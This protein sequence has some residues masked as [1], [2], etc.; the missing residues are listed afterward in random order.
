MPRGAQH[1]LEIGGAERALARLVDHRLAGERRELGNDLPARL[2]AH[3]DAAA[4]ARIA[5]AGADLLRAPALVG[6]QVGEVGAM[7]FA[8][9]D[10]VPARLARGGQQLLDRLDRR[11]G[12]RQVVAHLVDIAADAAEVGLHVD[13]DQRG[14]L[15]AAGRRSTA[16]DRDGIRRAWLPWALLFDGAELAGRAAQAALGRAGRD[17]QGERQHIGRGAEQVVALGDADRLQRRADRA[18]RA[19]QQRGPQA[20]DRDPSARRSPAPRPSGPGRS[21]GPRSSCRDSRATGTRRRRRRR[22][23]RSRSRSGARGRPRRRS[24]APHRRSRRPAA[25]SGPSACS[26][27]AQAM[28]EGR[29]RCRSTK[30]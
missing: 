22:R 15:R 9:M 23:R 6:R 24:P 27:S 8:R 17:H 26:C 14:V 19:E 3:Q 30:R 20:A 10:D 13:D 5:D 1:Q 28:R 4:R 12:Q 7:A 25:R 16:R 2:A 21:T 18:G 11:A 29:A